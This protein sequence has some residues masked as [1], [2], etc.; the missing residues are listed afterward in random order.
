M[1]GENKCSAQVEAIRQAAPVAKGVLPLL[2][3]VRAQVKYYA[4]IDLKSFYASVECVERGMDPFKE[5]L[6]VADP[7]RGRGAICLAIS[8]ALKKLGVRNRC[9][10][11]EI[12]SYIQYTIALPRMKKY[13]EY[14]ESIYRMYLDYLAPEDIHVY[15]IDECFLYLS[16]YLSLYKRT[17]KEML[18]MLLGLITEKFN[19]CATSGLGTNMYLAKIALDI[20]A[21]HRPDNIGY[22]DEELF[23]KEMWD[24]K[25]LTDFWNIGRGTARRLA[26]KGIYTMREVA[27]ADKNMLYKEF[28]VNAEYLIDHAWGRESCTIEDIQHYHTKSKSISNSQILFEDYDYKDAYIVL[29]EMVE[30][31]SLKLVE[32]QLLCNSVSLFIRYSKD[33]HP[34]TGGAQHLPQGTDSFQVLE[35]YFSK[36]YL[37]TTTR[38][39][40][41]RQLAVSANNLSSLGEEGQTLFSP[42]SVNE[43]KDRD[44]QQ[45]LLDI[46]GKYGK[47]SILRGLSYREKATGKIRNTLIGGHNGG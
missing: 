16:P 14:S 47:N 27:Q 20:L 10:L 1:A 18:Q 3:G 43:E 32:K 33:C 19:I 2:S 45:A 21:K 39:A 26:K 41:I 36:L 25:P 29:Q 8:P 12:P 9:R 30:F 34:P 13:M 11:F 7:A 35:E 15:S 37:L 24:Y 44:M 42:Y 28:G 23:Q 31:L 22:L 40:P 46:K 5:N 38:S 4:V 17:P 6:V